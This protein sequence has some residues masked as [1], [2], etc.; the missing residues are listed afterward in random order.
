MPWISAV[1]CCLPCVRDGILIGIQQLFDYIPMLYERQAATRTFPLEH[2]IEY[3]II[4]YKVLKKTQ[5]P[6]VYNIYDYRCTILP[7]VLSI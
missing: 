2:C 5:I 1:T 6:Y 7:N 4:L 3:S